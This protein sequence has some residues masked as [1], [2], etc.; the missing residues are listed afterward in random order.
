MMLR[1][2]GHVETAHR[3]AIAGTLEVA[4]GDGK[5]SFRADS[6]GFE[7]DA[8]AGILRKILKLRVD[9]LYARAVGG[10]VFDGRLKPFAVQFE[11]TAT[12][13]LHAPRRGLL[14]TLGNDAER[15]ARHDQVEEVPA[16][17]HQRD[18]GL[19][20]LGVDLVDGHRHPHQ[21][22][23]EDDEERP[24][25]LRE[26]ALVYRFILA[27]DLEGGLAGIEDD[28]HHGRQQV[29]RLHI[30]VKLGYPRP[31]ECAVK[32]VLHHQVHDHV[33]ERV[34]HELAAGGGEYLQVEEKVE[35]R[36]EEKDR[37]R[38]RKQPE[39][40]RGHVAEA[41]REREAALQRGKA[42]PQ[43]LHHALR[44]PTALADEAGEGRRLQACDQRLVDV[45]AVPP[46]RMQFDRR[47]AVLGDGNTAE[48]VRLEQRLAPQD[49]RRAA[50]EGSVPLVQ[51]ALDDA[52]EHLVLRGHLLEGAQIALH[53]IGI[54]EEVRRLHQE[55]PWILIEIANGFLEEIARRRVVSIEHGNQ[56]AR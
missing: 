4:D 53:R 9:H 28:G 14:A 17:N 55:Q 39:Q 33:G 10:D 40:R 31:A 35:E 37:A 16:A 19:V 26:P 52:V 38:K 51:P 2:L 56:L 21:K 25:D 27:R 22:Q 46:A 29:D 15:T 1:F 12:T 24:A 3:D 54:E 42:E 30:L 18:V 6:K 7:P 13:D 8:R 48:A 20:R 41:L 11:I 45:D 36:R 44:P 34:G 5:D 32:V 43:N 47:L 49:G 23:R 50:E